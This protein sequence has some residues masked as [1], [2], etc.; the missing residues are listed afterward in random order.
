MRKRPK[1]V[2]LELTFLIKCREHEC[3]ALCLE[4]DIASC[5]NTEDEAVESLK[6]LIELYIFDC[7]ENDEYPIPMRPVPKDALNDFLQP[8][9]C[10]E[11]QTFISRHIKMTP[12]SYAPA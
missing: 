11:E 8:N 12:S 3:T 1:E 6:G 2:N 7:L 4:L 9:R 10:S 5:G